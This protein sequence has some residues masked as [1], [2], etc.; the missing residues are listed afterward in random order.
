MRSLF[1]ALVVVVISTPLFASEA[2]P[3]AVGAHTQVR[4]TSYSCDQSA[5]THGMSFSGMPDI[6][7]NA[8]IPVHKKNPVGITLDLALANYKNNYTASS[9]DYSRSL[10]YLTITPGIAFDYATFGIA[11]GL[12]MGYKRMNETSGAEENDKWSYLGSGGNTFEKTG[13][14]AK[15]M[16]NMSIEARLG[17]AYPIMKQADGSRLNLTGHVGYMVTK[18]FKEG[19][20]PTT[21]T[22]RSNGSMWSIALGMQYYFVL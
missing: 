22:E 10:S 20:Y 6:G 2:N 9:V 13:D 18:L 8:Y 17:A 12:P 15:D 21:N 19:Y 1:L 7:I 14:N 5:E 16:M 11:I 3:F 4:M